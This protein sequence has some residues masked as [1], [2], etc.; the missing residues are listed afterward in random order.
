MDIAFA[1]DV[2]SYL[3]D[4]I[5]HVSPTRLYPLFPIREKVIAIKLSSAA[6][7]VK[8]DLVESFTRA[9]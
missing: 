5:R 8:F 7:V 3:Y 2:Q 1:R 6:R 9:I 4:L